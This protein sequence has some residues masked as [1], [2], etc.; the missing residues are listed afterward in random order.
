MNTSSLACIG[1]KKKFKYA[2]F[3][4]GICSKSFSG[5]ESLE[6]HMRNHITSADSPRTGSDEE[7]ETDSHGGKYRNEKKLL[8]CTPD[9]LTTDSKD[10]AHCKICMKLCKYKNSLQSHMRH[11]TK[12]KRYQC[13]KC[14]LCSDREYDVIRHITKIHGLTNSYKRYLRLNNEY[15]C[16]KCSKLF[17]D[18][19][20]LN[21]HSIECLQSTGEALINGRIRSNMPSG[22]CNVEEHMHMSTHTSNVT[23]M[24]TI[25]YK[26]NVCYK[27]I[28]GRW[29]IIQHVK[30]IHGVSLPSN[31]L[32]SRE[33]NNMKDHTPQTSGEF[34]AAAKSNVNSK[35]NSA[36][37]PL[38]RK[39][40]LKSY[41]C[42]PCGMLT[43]G[44]MDLKMHLSKVHGKS[45]KTVS[46]FIT[47]VCCK[48]NTQL[49]DIKAWNKH[50]VKCMVYCRI[51][52]VYYSSRKVLYKHMRLHTGI[53]PYQCKLCDKRCIQ[54]SSCSYHV[55]SIHKVERSAALLYIAC[56]LPQIF[57][58]CQCNEYFNCESQLNEHFVECCQKLEPKKDRALVFKGNLNQPS[59]LIK[60]NIV[61]QASVIIKKNIITNQP[62]V[63][64]V[65]DGPSVCVKNKESSDQPSVTLSS[66]ANLSIF[67]CKVCLRKFG[68]PQHLQRH[69]RSHTGIV[70]YICNVCDHRCLSKCNIVSHITRHG[71]SRK[72]TLS[73]FTNVYFNRPYACNKCNKL[74]NLESHLNEHYAN[75]AN[76][77]DKHK[78]EK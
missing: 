57:V 18:E 77:Q 59:V 48:C 75:C 33:V 78:C 73:H 34:E 14:R 26:C 36:V 3:R 43:P 21:K 69:M 7:V 76:T 47:Y 28:L 53:K 15:K 52:S 9:N 24:P 25:K 41:K 2:E 49:P 54:Q 23:S 61:D 6:I 72:D 20:D 71:Y 56:V 22:G 31:E 13:R 30:Y 66:D 29:R 4:C 42:K 32:Y 70:P 64:N 55:H 63:K 74:F 11:H 19:N 38:P 35:K 68:T 8:K 27:E 44:L 5:N 45:I 51:C 62:L 17:D 58:C 16:F 40:S 12:Y 50:S 37:C 65:M 39:N 46:N 67:R 60:N 10:M 1:A